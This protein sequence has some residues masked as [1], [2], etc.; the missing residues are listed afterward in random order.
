MLPDVA[1]GE[2]LSPTRCAQAVQSSQEP[3]RIEPTDPTR[4]ATAA[5]TESGPRIRHQERCEGRRPEERCV[6]VGEDP[7]VGSHHPVTLAVGG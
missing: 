1:E 2:R 3:G 4:Q 6:S 5:Q 7:A